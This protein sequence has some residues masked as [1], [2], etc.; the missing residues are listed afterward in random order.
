MFVL[1]CANSP[2]NEHVNR[3]RTDKYSFWY[4][5]CRCVDALYFIY[6]NRQN[7]NCYM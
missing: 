6:S 5:S 2:F 4:Y 7:T 3:T 1:Y